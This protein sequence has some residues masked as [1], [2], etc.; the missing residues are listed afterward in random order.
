MKYTVISLLRAMVPWAMVCAAATV[1][2]SAAAAPVQPHSAEKQADNLVDP[3]AEPAQPGAA[4]VASNVDVD[5]S[6]ADKGHG[7]YK[8]F[9]QKCH[10]LDMVTPGGG[11]FDLRTFP[12]DDKP[13]FINSVTNGKRA[14]PAWGAVL[15]PGDIDALW[16]YVAS[17]QINRNSSSNG[18]TAQ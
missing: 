6:L 2:V 16:A 18:K 12:L 5:L 7:M 9:C 15:K 4:P 10:G 3:N 1:S 8:S 14:M 13:R 17:Y 11:F